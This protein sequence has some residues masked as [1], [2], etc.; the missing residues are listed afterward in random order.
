MLKYFA[1]GLL[2]AGVLSCGKDT[3]VVEKYEQPPGQP[4]NPGDIDPEPGEK[5]TYDQMRLLLDEYCVVCHSTSPFITD[6]EA[7]LRNSSAK[8][9]IF[10]KRMPPSNAPKKLGE[11]D[12]AIMLNFF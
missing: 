2:A 8:D 11:G 3:H 10:S 1:I 9:Q 5:I 4:P 7:A 6:G 12:R